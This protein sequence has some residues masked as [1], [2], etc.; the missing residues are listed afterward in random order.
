MSDSFGGNGPLSPTGAGGKFFRDETSATAPTAS[1]A[2]RRTD[3]KD[4]INGP[5]G[6]PEITTQNRK[7]D[8]DSPFNS[9][10]RSTT[11]PLSA[12]LNGPASPWGTGPSSSGFGTMGA[13]GNFAAGPSSTSQDQMEKRPGFG[14]ARGGSRFK[15]LLAK[16]S[17]EDAPSIKEK[18]SI[19]SL[20]RLLETEGEDQQSRQQESFRTR[21]ARSETNPYGENISRD[22][23]AALGHNPDPG[24]ATSALEQLGFSSF[25]MPSNV[26][27]RDFMQQGQQHGHTHQTPS[28]TP[29]W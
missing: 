13:F 23:S 17:A 5:D 25:G 12:N 21:P 1:L 24:A 7:I 2:R 9:L 11:G 28:Y 22:D 19:V 29:T 4:D 20:E 14:S 16:N 18:G 8:L 3:L 10:K 26:G 27:T 15:D 6:E